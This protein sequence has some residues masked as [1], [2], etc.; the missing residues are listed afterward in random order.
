MMRIVLPII[1]CLALAG[2]NQIR[3]EENEP[4]VVQSVDLERYAG[5]WY[6]IAKI[7]NRFQKK[8][9][10]NTTVVNRCTKEDGK[11]ITARGI[12]KI[13]DTTTFAKLKVSFVSLLGIRFFWGDYWI[14][15]L[16][17]DYQWAIVGNPSRQYGWILSRTPQLLDD[18]RNRVNDI[19]R[20][21]GYDPDRFVNTMHEKK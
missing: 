12:A 16:D 15:G 20:I 7:P 14:I 3:G 5:V 13:A 19:L 2:K 1:L 6:E 11:I 21:Q 4:K 9:A 8:C 10:R 17:E 18:Q